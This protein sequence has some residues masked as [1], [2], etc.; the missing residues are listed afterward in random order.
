[1]T[2]AMPRAQGLGPLSVGLYLEQAEYGF[3]GPDPRDS[4]S[5]VL[6]GAWEPAF[7]I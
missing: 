6:N 1:M 4:D 5:E 3:L 2:E 7:I